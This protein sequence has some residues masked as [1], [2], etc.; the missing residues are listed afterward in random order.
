MNWIGSWMN[1]QNSSERNIEK[2]NTVELHLFGYAENP[3]NW[4]FFFK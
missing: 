3:G 1:P 2:M 4:N